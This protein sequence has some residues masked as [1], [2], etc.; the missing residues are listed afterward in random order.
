M[1]G[2]ETKSRIGSFVRDKLIERKGQ[3]YRKQNESQTRVEIKQDRY[4]PLKQRRECRGTI[5]SII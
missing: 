2:K 4:P 1:F 5:A 3:E